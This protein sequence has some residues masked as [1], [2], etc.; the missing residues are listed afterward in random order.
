MTEILYFVMAKVTSEGFEKVVQE[1][2]VLKETG[3]QFKI[4]SDSPH[5]RLVVLKSELGATNTA[6]RETKV[7]FNSFWLGDGADKLLADCA[8]QA[9]QEVKTRWRIASALLNSVQLDSAF[10]NREREEL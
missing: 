5:N 7:E 4:V 10:E 6:M 3:K 8:R 1:V 2:K 9:E